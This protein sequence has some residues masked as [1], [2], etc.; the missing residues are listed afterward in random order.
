M[1]TGETGFKGSRGLGFKGRRKIGK[2]WNRRIHDLKE[3]MV[4]MIEDSH[5]NPGTLESWNP[6]SPKEVTRNGESNSDGGFVF[7]GG[8]GN[9]CGVWG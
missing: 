8:L 7:G 6:K 5:W 3:I 9:E 4:L 2:R 1:I